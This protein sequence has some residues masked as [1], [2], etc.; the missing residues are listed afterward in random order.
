[1]PLVECPDCGRMV[2]DQA[3]ACPNCGRPVAA[4][5]Q[6]KPES[7]LV[8]P[9]EKPQG[10][11]LLKFVGA[12]LFLGGIAFAVYY[13]AY[14]DTIVA[15]PTTEIFG[16]QIGGGRVHNLGLMQERQNGLIFSSVAAVVGLLLVFMADRINKA[17]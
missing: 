16:Q 12:L 5:P 11:L 7:S 15:V 6:V 10:S 13:F 2:S 4:R 8:L 17:T 3:D 14:F 1:M 9:G